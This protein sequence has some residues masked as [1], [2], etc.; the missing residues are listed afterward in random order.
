MAS[1]TLD[2]RFDGTNRVA[3]SQVL[4]RSTIQTNG[5]GHGLFI[6]L[7]ITANKKPVAIEDGNGYFTD[8]VMPTT[9][10]EARGKYVFALYKREFGPG[11]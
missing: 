8:V 10:V 3:I 9:Y 5:L 2:V 6:K 11:K 1:L 4:L 7:S